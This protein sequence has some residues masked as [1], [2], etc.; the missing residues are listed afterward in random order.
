MVVNCEQVWQEIS[1]YL[2]NDIDPSLRTALEEHVRQCKRCTAVLN[3]TRN[4]I[5]LY[6]DER[7]LQLPMGFSWRLRRKLAGIMPARRGTVYGWLVAVA[8]L[9]LFT[10]SL[11]L[12]RS[13][14]SSRPAARSEHAQPGK[15]IPGELTVLVA[16]HG[17][18]FHI[19]GCTFI[20]DKEGAVRSMTAREA[21]KEGY[22]PC[23]R[24]LGEYLSNLAAKFVS[25]QAWAAL[26][27]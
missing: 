14:A 19:A 18:L 23:A 11:G 2:E 17:K 26:L 12:A 5:H 13:A 15:R 6:A 25:K 1:N 27:R 16:E 20:H 21:M 10:G 22:T 7:L 9:G 8:A 3:G 4:I 24:C